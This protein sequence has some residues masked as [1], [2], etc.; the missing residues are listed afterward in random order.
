MPL[1]TVANSLHFSPFPL[2]ATSV[3]ACVRCVTVDRWTT[4][5]PPFVLFDVR[6][7]FSDVSVVL[8][9]TDL[10][11]HVYDANGVSRLSIRE[12]YT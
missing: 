3:K 6:N 1:D 2:A 5:T 8:Y 10:L 12:E 7:A 9:R 4:W 11:S